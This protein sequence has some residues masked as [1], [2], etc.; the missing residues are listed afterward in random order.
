MLLGNHWF[1]VA[2]AQPKDVIDSLGGF[3]ASMLKKEYTEL[4]WDTM[5]DAAP[6]PAFVLVEVEQL[7]PVEKKSDYEKMVGERSSI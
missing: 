4:E 2:R 5:V 3:T 6:F 1:S 7:I